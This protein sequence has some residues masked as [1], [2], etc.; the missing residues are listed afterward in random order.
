MDGRIAV[1]TYSHHWADSEGRLI[2][3]WDNTPHHPGLAGFP[4]HIHDG[5]SGS[6]EP[7]NPTHIFAVLDEIS[8]GMR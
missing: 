8:A 2:K 5:A 7:G 6:V 3:R 4:H 1:A